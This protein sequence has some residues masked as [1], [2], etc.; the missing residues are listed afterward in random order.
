MPTAAEQ[1]QIGRRAGSC[2]EPSATARVTPSQMAPTKPWRLISSAS[3]RMR[4]ATSG[5]L[6]FLI[7]AAFSLNPSHAFAQT[8]DLSN[9]KMTFNQDFT[10][11]KSLS[12]SNRGLF[13]P[14]G[15]TWIAHTPYNGDWVHFEAPSGPF[16]PF[17]LSDGHLTIRAQAIGDTYY[18]GILSSVDSGGTGFSQ[19][20][21]YFEMSAK[22]PTGPGTWSAFWMMSLPSLLNRSL[23]MGEIDVVEQYGDP[24]STLFSTVHL[25]DPSHSWTKLWEKQNLSKQPSMTSGFHSYGVDIQPD[26]LTFYYDRQRIGQF[27]NSIPGRSEKFDEPMYV[28]VDL[29]Y[30]GGYSGNDISHLLSGPQ[31]MQVQYIRVWQGSGGSNGTATDTSS[32][33]SITYPPAGLTLTNGSHVDIRGVSL[34]FTD[35]GNLE[36]TDSRKKVLWKTDVPAQC[37]GACRAVFQNDGNLVLSSPGNKA[38]WTSQ[39]WNNNLGWMTFSNRAPYLEISSEKDQT[40]WSTGVTN[41]IAIPR[42]SL[43]PHGSTAVRF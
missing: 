26:Y 21:G 20:F 40:L 2:G 22:L 3:L 34:I 31:D 29:A 4:S 9:Y 17:S 41:Q 37:G 12:V 42:K 25:W 23:P 18:G 16:H 6:L 15:T 39:S 5:I 7:I 27:P 1:S 33:N 8:M 13:A 14:P 30:G 43:D 36:I 38:Y 11:M 28:M 32:L 24:V 10:K 19:R 35:G